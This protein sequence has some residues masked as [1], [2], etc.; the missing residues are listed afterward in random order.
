MLV[1]G[2]ALPGWL[3]MYRSPVD[4]IVSTSITFAKLFGRMPLAE[5]SDRT[6]K[7]VITGPQKYVRNPLYLGVMLIVFGWALM[8]GQ[9]YLLVSGIAISFWFWLVQIPFEERELQVLFGDQYARYAEKVLILIPFTKRTAN[10]LH[11]SS[12]KD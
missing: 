12:A 4:M 6:E 11:G 9:T 3:F 1:A 7:L 2:L 5:R 10:K 8:N